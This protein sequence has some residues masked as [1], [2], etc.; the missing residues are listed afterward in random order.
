MP[1]YQV[2]PTGQTCA[3]AA[4]VPAARAAAIASIFSLLLIVHLRALCRNQEAISAAFRETPTRS[5]VFRLPHGRARSK[6]SSAGGN[7]RQKR[8]ERGGNETLPG[9]WWPPCSR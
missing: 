6:I 2:E 9:L 5:R 3:I 4:L 8:A 1:A 7:R